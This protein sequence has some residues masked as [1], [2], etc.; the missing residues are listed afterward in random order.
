MAEGLGEH[1]HRFP[2]SEGGARKALSCDMMCMSSEHRGGD[3]SESDSDSESDTGKVLSS[4][5]GSSSS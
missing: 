1:A 2:P 3:L 5:S 4:S